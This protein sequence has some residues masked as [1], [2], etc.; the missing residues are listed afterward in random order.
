MRPYRLETDEMSQAQHE[1]EEMQAAANS[2][3]R[4]AAAFHDAGKAGEASTASLL[5]AG[6]QKAA[7]N[8]R[9]RALRCVCC[10]GNLPDPNCPVCGRFYEH[11]QRSIH[12]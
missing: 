6:L 8:L 1:A 7:A 4:L 12:P 11:G 3:H 5:A 2:L 10:A 9:S